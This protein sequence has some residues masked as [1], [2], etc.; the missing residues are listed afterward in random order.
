[1]HSID[2][3]RIK[4]TFLQNHFSEKAVPK[5]TSELDKGWIF[6]DW[7]GRKITQTYGNGDDVWWFLHSRN[8]FLEPFYPLKLIG[9]YG[10][11]LFLQASGREW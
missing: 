1:M 3:E 5:S 7:R 8:N 2:Y 6:Q 9:I 4:R 11:M 10:D